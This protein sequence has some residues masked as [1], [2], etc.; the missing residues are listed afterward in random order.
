MQ[1][2]IRETCTVSSVVQ[3]QLKCGDDVEF[4]MAHHYEPLAAAML[5]RRLL[6]DPSLSNILL[7]TCTEY[8]VCN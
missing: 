4:D 8:I 6:A 7:N 2:E 1:R 3:M 5:L